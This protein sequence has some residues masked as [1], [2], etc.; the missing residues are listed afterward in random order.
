MIQW[1]LHFK[2]FDHDSSSISEGF[3]NADWLVGV[4]GLLTPRSLQVGV[5]SVEWELV[6]TKLNLCV[7]LER[8]VECSIKQ[9]SLYTLSIWT[10]DYSDR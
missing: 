9:I 8:T 7:E 2:F 1:Q 10:L 5:M 6:D 4:A 3:V